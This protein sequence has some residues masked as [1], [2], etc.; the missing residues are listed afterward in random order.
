MKN[1]IFIIAMVTL[2]ASCGIVKRKPAES[3]TAVQDK[4]I[5]YDA[6]IVPGVPYDGVS[7]SSTMNFRVNWSV[8]LYKIGFTKNII[9]SGSS[10]YSPYSEAKVMALY[11]EELGVPKEN[12]LLEPQ[13]EHSTENVYFSYLVAKE[14]G[15][16]NIALATDPFQSS[17]VKKF[18]RKHELPV[19]QIPIV[20]D[21]LDQF[22]N[23]EPRIQPM[24][25][26]NYNFKSIKEREGFFERLSGTFGKQIL[27][28]EEDLPN[29]K[30]VEKYSAQGRLLES[31]QSTSLER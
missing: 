1:K 18:I 7:W 5:V 3:F 31:N 14:N 13:A 10:V 2:L 27:W 9:F 15:L 23:P 17:S 22:S 30:L 29:Q 6:I 28:H 20:F 12:I 8:Y 16:K 25:A 21:S 4:N 26:Y 11:A 24:V 19:E